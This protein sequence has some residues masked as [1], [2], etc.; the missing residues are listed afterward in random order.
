MITYNAVIADDHALVRAGLRELLLTLPNVNVVG[1]AGDGMEAIELCQQIK[2]DIVVLDIAMP[3][4]RGLEAI[5]E[6]KR[7]SPDSRILIISMY[8]KQDYVREAFKNGAT[9]YLLKE[10]AAEEL[11]IAINTLIEGE[12]YISPAL[13]KIIIKG[14]IRGD[15]HTLHAK[16]H[17][18]SNLTERELVVVKLLCEG[19]TN[20]KVAETLHISIKTVETHRHRIMEKLNLDSFAALVKYAVREGI[21][22]A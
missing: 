7:F 10:A 19:Y 12:V 16:S 8:N 9:G 1:E 3:K 4:M 22:E 21:I 20:R 15:G 14:W 18:G 11:K 2:P 13:S 6:I 17:N 5:K